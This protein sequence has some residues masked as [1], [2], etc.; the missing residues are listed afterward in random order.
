M[1]NFQNISYIARCLLLS[2]IILP[3]FFSCERVKKQN[4]AKTVEEYYDTFK[5]RKDFDKFMSFYDDEVV[6][7]DV[8]NADR[9]I[10][11]KELTEF[12]DWNNPDFQKGAADALVIYEQ[13]IEGNKVVTRGYYTEFLWGGTKFEAMHFVMILTFNESGKIIKHID[14]IN[15]P[16][17]LIDYNNRRNSNE[18]IR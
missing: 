2:T 10:G 3:S 18:W 16:S 9:I 11:K 1:V 6:L 17:N 4:I 14:W 7:E 8:V 5:E 13:I 12:F 15:Y